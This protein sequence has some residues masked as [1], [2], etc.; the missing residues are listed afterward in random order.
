MQVRQN[1][2]DVNYPVI[3]FFSKLKGEQGSVVESLLFIE[4]L[5]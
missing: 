3:A 2:L 1:Y 5:L 4:N